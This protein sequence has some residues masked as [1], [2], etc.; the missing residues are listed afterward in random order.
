MG[1]E[2]HATDDPEFF[3]VWDA[4]ADIGCIYHSKPDEDDD[5]EGWVASMNHA[6]WASDPQGTVAEAVREVWVMYGWLLEER[7][8]LDG[9]RNRWL[10]VVSV[11]MGGQSRRW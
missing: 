4:H 1:I 9:R 7:R 11:P 5:R 8:A 6:G 10:R 2:L 3:E